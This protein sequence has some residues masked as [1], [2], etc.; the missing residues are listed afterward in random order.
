MSQ[1]IWQLSDQGSHAVKE[2]LSLRV[3]QARGKLF[4]LSHL[5][6]I[7]KFGPQLSILPMYWFALWLILAHVDCFSNWENWFGDK[8]Y[9]ATESGLP[10]VHS[11]VFLQGFLSKSLKFSILASLLMEGCFASLYQNALHQTD[12]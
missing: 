8:Q 2:K 6:H 12:T 1:R 10:N 5:K 7:F 9:R 3:S 4:F 11:A